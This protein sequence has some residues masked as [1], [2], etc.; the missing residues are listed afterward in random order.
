MRHKQDVAKPPKWRAR[1]LLLRWLRGFFDV[2][3]TLLARRGIRLSTISSNWFT[4]SRTSATSTPT[5]KS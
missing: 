1:P 2:A 5:S 4:P 3:A